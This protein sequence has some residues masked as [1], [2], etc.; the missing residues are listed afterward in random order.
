MFFVFK[1]MGGE[2]IPTGQLN[3]RQLILEYLMKIPKGMKPILFKKSLFLSVE[4]RSDD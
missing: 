1:L 4:I 3:I 2:A